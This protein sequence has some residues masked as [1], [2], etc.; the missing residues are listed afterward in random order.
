MKDIRK[1]K[2]SEI[3]VRVGRVIKT[4]SFS[5][6]TLLLYKNARVD[7]AILD[8][9][10][11]PFGW[12]RRHEVVNGN[13]Y[14]TVSVYDK[15]NGQ[16]VSKQDCGTESNTEAEKGEA[17]DSFKR[18][19]VNWGIGREL[20]TAPDILISCELDDKGK[21][22]AGTSWTVGEIGYDEN[23]DI[24][25]LTIVQHTRKKQDEVVFSFGVK[26]EDQGVVKTYKK[27]YSCKVC[28]KA[29]NDVAGDMTKKRYGECLCSNDCVD[30]FLALL[31]DTP[32]PMVN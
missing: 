32:F 2:A 4:Q 21:V 7:M 24:C 3:D 1:L 5:G 11:T 19:C 26:G 6:V 18:A 23:G 15:E 13:M 22:K 20:Y 8:E 9:L 31:D 12:T 28:K 30:K 14:C 27:C 17:S 10:F 16:W 29:V 25:R